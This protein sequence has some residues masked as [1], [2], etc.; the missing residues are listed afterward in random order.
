MPASASAG[1]AEDDEL[2]ELD[3][4]VEAE[5]RDHDRA[6]EQAAQVVGESGAM[7]QAEDAGEERTVAA[8]QRRACAVAHER[9]SRAR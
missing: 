4:D 1:Q 2:P 6:G 8:A 3:A 9:G 7:H 5:E